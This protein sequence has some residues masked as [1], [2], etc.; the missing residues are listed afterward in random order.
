[1]FY[2]SESTILLSVIGMVGVL[3]TAIVLT[4]GFIRAPRLL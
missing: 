2:P 3:G 1:M 4:Y